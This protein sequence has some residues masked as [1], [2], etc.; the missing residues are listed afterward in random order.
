MLSIP[1]Y[2]V[3]VG[4]WSFNL[5]KLLTQNLDRFKFYRQNEQLLRD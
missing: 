3:Y 2:I 1:S 5:F 4:G